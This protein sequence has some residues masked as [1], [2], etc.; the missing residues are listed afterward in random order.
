MVGFETLLFSAWEAALAQQPARAA[1]PPLKTDLGPRLGRHLLGGLGL[2]LGLGFGLWDAPLNL[3]NIRSRLWHGDGLRGGVT[4][5][6]NV[7]KGCGMGV[8][9]PSP[10]P[11]RTAARPPSSSGAV[12]GS[13]GGGASKP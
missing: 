1:L 11:A 8:S 5:L 2:G 13:S 10:A 3:L 4:R 12:N 9:P 7:E 6:F